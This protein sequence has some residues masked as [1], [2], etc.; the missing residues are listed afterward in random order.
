PPP[1]PAPPT[2]CRDAPRTAVLPGP[3]HARATPPH[4]NGFFASDPGPLRLPAEGQEFLVP[5]SGQ[6]SVNVTTNG[7]GDASFSVG[8]NVPVTPGRVITATATDPVGNTSELSAGLPTLPPT[9]LT[10][11]SA[12]PTAT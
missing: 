10:L 12:G 8:L 9:T 3:R 6:P 5:V 7:S 11:F 1:S 4:R 2:D